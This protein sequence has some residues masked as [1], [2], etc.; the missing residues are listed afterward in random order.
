MHVALVHAEGRE[1]ADFQKRGTGID[2]ASDAFAGQ[3]LAASDV[4]FAGLA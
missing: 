3:K 4:T 2:Q 1:R